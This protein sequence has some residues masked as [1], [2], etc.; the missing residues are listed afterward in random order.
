MTALSVPVFREDGMVAGSLSISGPD[1]RM[2]PDVI[3]RFIPLLRDAG[4][5][6]SSAMG[7]RSERVQVDLVAI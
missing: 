7:F 4:R 5:S 2:Q 6:L 3:V 1:V